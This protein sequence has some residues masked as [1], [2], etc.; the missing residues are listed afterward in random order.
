VQPGLFLD[1]NRVNQPIMLDQPRYHY[2]TALVSAIGRRDLQEDAVVGHFPAESGLGYVVLADGMGGHAAGDVASRIVVQEFCAE[3]ARH[4]EDPAQL[5]QNVGSVLR[6]AMA[7]AN[8]QVGRHATDQPELRSMGSTLVASLIVRNRLYWISVGDSPLYLLRGNRMSRLN[9]EH[10]MARR[11]DRMVAG[12]LISQA[13]ADQNP[14]RYCL[15]S[16]LLGVQVP[17]IDCRDRPIELLDGDILVVASDGLLS[18]DEQRIAALIYDCRDQPSA[19]I[20]ARLL[21]D[22]AAA[23]DPDQDNVTLCLV[24]ISAQAVGAL[25]VA[26]SAPSARPPAVQRTTVRLQVRRS[27]T[28]LARTIT[29]IAERER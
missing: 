9:Q 20:N 8:G 7:R 22:I 14:D 17:E 13:E 24:K 12:G 21:Q 27:G 4:A 11:L 19:E 5:E 10:S 15:T 28:R 23:D 29:T 2:D 18:I 3:L 1:G 16:A 25:P 26:A 6:Q